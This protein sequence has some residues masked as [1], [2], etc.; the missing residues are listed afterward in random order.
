[1]E[2][3]CNS[4]DRDFT[5]PPPQVLQHGQNVRLEWS[6][7]NTRFLTKRG[8]RNPVRRNQTWTLTPRITPRLQSHNA[9]EKDDLGLGDGAFGTRDEKHQVALRDKALGQARL[10]L[11]DRVCPRRVHDRDLL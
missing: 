8:Y 2:F 1:M 3:G 11:D 7:T 4:F 9:E 5:Q 6:Y 10:L